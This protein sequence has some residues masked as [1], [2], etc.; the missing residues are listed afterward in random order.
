MRYGFS[1]THSY[2]PLR[3]TASF[4][5]VAF[6]GGGAAVVVERYILGEGLGAEALFQG[7]GTETEHVSIHLFQ[8]Q[9][10]HLF[11]VQTI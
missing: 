7:V 2:R 3:P 5:G 1:Q 4:P 6:A 11:Q 8:V 9:A 10:I